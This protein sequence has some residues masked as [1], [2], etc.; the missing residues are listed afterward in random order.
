MCW[1]R[2]KPSRS[3]VAQTSLDYDRETKAPLYAASGIPEYWVV[4]VNSCV[5]EVHDEPLE[6]RYCRLRT[7]KGE[8]AVAPAAFPDVLLGVGELFAE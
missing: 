7:F 3:E 5:L 4:D 6:G 2:S 1:K 8:D